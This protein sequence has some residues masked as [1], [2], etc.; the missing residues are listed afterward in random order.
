MGCPHARS[1]TDGTG[2]SCPVGRLVAE[3]SSPYP[4]HGPLPGPACPQGL[5]VHKR[6]SPAPRRRFPRR[7]PAPAR[8]APRRPA[9]TPWGLALCHFQ[10]LSRPL[11]FVVGPAGRPSLSQV[12][13]LSFSRPHLPGSIRSAEH[14]A[15]GVLNWG[16]WPAPPVHPV[17]ITLCCSWGRP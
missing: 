15:L 7:P 12:M 1:G 4:Q 6:L 14:G 16:V 3:L 2:F 8:P 13:I 11:F 17:C 5:R 10:M 9:R